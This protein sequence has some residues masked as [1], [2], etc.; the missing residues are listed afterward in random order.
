MSA[1]HG[2]PLGP[3]SAPAVKGPQLVPP[4]ETVP[5]QVPLESTAWGDLHPLAP[6]LIVAGIALIGAVT[7]V[8]SAAIWLLVRNTGVGWMFQ[9]NS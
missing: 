7:F 4:R 8:G 5:A 3:V 6:A 2:K 1:A 9:G